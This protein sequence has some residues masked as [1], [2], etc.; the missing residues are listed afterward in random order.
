[1]TAK[2]TK[3]YQSLKEFSE[4][5]SHEMQ[6]PLA[7]IGNRVEL[8][9]QETQDEKEIKTLNDVNRATNR[10]TKLQKA[11]ALLTK[12]SNKEF[13]DHKRIRLRTI[14]ENQ[15]ENFRDLISYKKISFKYEIED[16]PVLIVNGYLLEILI[17]NLF[18]NAIYHNVEGG[19]IYIKV[20]GTYLEISNTGAVPDIDPTLYFDRFRKG[21]PDSETSGL[22]L[23]IVK[24]ICDFY[25]Y[26]IKYTYEK[27]MHILKV[28]F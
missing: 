10:L 25:G 4:N 2:M 19:K 13:T 27:G 16:D 28:S 11:L 12:L 20:L 24:Q 9:L 14:V 1:M 21:K 8:L 18:N 15:I 23:S 7:I 22:G 6:T 26:E 3:D 5:A 17:S